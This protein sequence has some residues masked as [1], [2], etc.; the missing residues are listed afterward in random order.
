MVFNKEYYHVRRALARCTE[1]QGRRSITE[2]VRQWGL[3]AMPK[4]LSEIE[5]L[6]RNLLDRPFCISQELPDSEVLQLSQDWLNENPYAFPP[7]ALI[8]RCLQKVNHP[9]R[10][11]VY[12]L[13]CA[14]LESPTLVPLLLQ[15]LIDNPIILPNLPHILKNTQGDPHPQV[16]NGHMILAAWPIS[17]IQEIRADYHKKLELSSKHLGAQGRQDRA[18]QHGSYG[19]AE[20]T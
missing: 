19:V 20:D 3:D 4:D 2:V 9:G 18:I 1:H 14:D 13:D 8:G 10:S 12:A 11:E 6:F 7:F 17:G 15:M 5:L 16:I